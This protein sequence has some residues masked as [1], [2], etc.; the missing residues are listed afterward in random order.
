MTAPVLAALVG[1]MAGLH[2]A[3]WGMYKDAPHEGFSFRKYLRS[4]FLGSVLSVVVQ[5]LTGL[6]PR[7]PASLLLL[8][9]STYAVERAVA[10]IYKTFLR[11]EDQSKYFI[12]M[13]FHVMGRV[14]Q[15]RPARLGAGFLYTA[16][17]VGLVVALMHFDL[18]KFFRSPA[19]ALLYASGL[20]Y[21]TDSMLAMTLAATGY[22][23]ATM[24]T[25]K[26]FYFPTRPRGKFA[27]RP[28]RYPELR[29]WCRKFVPLYIAIWLAVA[30][31]LAAALMTVPPRSPLVIESSRE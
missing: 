22:T 10:E 28:I 18:F 2:A 9:G 4:P 13:Q 25:Y 7:D 20:S 24:E 8:F 17:L 26:T 27:G 21:L 12:P 16:L 29:Q 23:V 30:G 19:L 31:S 6:D 1:L 5:A 3:T 11:E 14:V 15:S